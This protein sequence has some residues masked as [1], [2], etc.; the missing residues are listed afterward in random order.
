MENG[1]FPP[2]RID[3]DRI[4]SDEFAEG[5]YSGNMACYLRSIGVMSYMYYNFNHNSNFVVTSERK[6]IALLFD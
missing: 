5:T 3:V 1:Q 6:C 4:Y 2:T